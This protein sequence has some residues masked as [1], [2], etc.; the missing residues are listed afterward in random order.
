MSRGGGVRTEGN[1]I[2][3]EQATPSGDVWFTPWIVVGGAWTF[4]IYYFLTGDL[5]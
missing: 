5:F 4:L 2:C 1:P 3:A